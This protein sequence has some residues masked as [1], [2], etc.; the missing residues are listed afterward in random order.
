[1]NVISK[2][3]WLFVVLCFFGS[4]SIEI[5]NIPGRKTRPKE[6]IFERPNI[7]TGTSSISSSFFRFLGQ[8][9]V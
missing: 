6:Q 3:T 4:Y 7:V 8:W 1:M 9:Y 5:T 2:H